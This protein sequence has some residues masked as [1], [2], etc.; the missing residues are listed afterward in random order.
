MAQGTKTALFSR[1]TAGG[2]LAIEDQSVSTGNRWYVDSG[3]T[4]TGGN[5]VG[6]GRSPDKPFL[7]WAYALSSD[8][9]DL[10]SGDRIYLMEGHTESLTSA[11][12]VA[13]DR[14]GIST[15]GLGE[16]TD[17][18]QITFASSDNSAS[19]L[20]TAANT[21]IKNIVGICS[22]DGLSNAFHV[23]AADCTLDIEWQDGSNTVEAATVVLT[24][25]D[26]DRLT[27]KLRYMGFDNGDACVAPISLV[28]TAQTRISIDF[29]GLASTAVVDMPTSC[30]DVVVRGYMYNEGTT[31]FSKSVKDTSGTSTWFADFFDGAAGSR[32]SGGSGGALAAD[33]IG[34]VASQT[35]SIGTQVSTLSSTTVSE[36]SSVGTLTSTGNST[37]TVVSSKTTSVGTLASTG[38]STGT[39][40]SSKT[41][42]VGTLASTGNSTGTIGSS[43]TTSV[44][45][46]TSTGNSTGTITGSKATS[47]GTVTV[48]T[49]SKATSIG[50][51]LST[52]TSTNTSITNSVATLNS[53]Q[54]ST[55]IS[56]LDSL[57][58]A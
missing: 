26:A 53:T 37:G 36:T 29:Y 56:K 30:D 46:L 57:P 9:T 23:Q 11:G 16:G 7:T 54:Y 44:G 33:D 43:K 2:V 58:S 28:G 10:N 32:A 6:H 27:V 12:A 45:T 20:I 14:A 52:Q 24:N 1:K 51:Q 48:A 13:I 47:T 5:T 41:T 3:S 15:I 18:P 35:T 55:I 34:T 8:V 4:S 17:R 42:S 25:A 40:V 19:V 21:V 50:T 39:V 22:D 49:G 31:D 38:N